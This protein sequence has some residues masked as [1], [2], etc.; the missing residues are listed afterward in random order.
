MEEKSNHS[1]NGVER[2]LDLRKIR[3]I[4]WK[5]WLIISRDKLRLIPLFIFPFIMVILFGTTA[6]VSPKHI[7]A[8]IVDYDNTPVSQS[9]QSL[10][11]SNEL[12]SIKTQVGSQE[13][14]KKLIDEGQISVLF[15]IPKGFTQELD[16]GNTADL[17]VII[18]QSDPSVAQITQASTEEFVQSVSQEITQQRIVMLT[19]EE[20]QLQSTLAQTKAAIAVPLMINNQPTVAKMDS[21]FRQGMYAGSLTSTALGGIAQQEV[22]SIGPPVSPDAV[23]QSNYVEGEV[24]LFALMQSDVQLG[25]YQQAESYQTLQHTSSMAVA[26]LQSVYGEARYIESTAEAEQGAAKISYNLIDA[27]SGQVAQLQNDTQNVAMNS[28]SLALNLIQPYGNGLRGIDYLL[29]N[30]LALIAFQGSVMGLG[31]AVAGERRDGSLT[32]VFLTPT[33]NITIIAGTLLYYVLQQSVQTMLIVLAAIAFFGLIVKGSLL[34]ILCIIVLFSA[35]SCGVGMIISVITRSQ[36]QYMAV[37]GLTSLPML[38]LAGVFIPIETMPAPLQ[39]LTRALPITYA[40]DALRGVMIKGFG[41]GQVIPD[42]TFLVAFGLVTMS[43]SLLIFKR[44]LI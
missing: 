17:D 29:P 19:K 42:L 41:L 30:I 36:E 43:L 35:G 2:L 24:P 18:D 5:N 13:E 22:S 16:S 33:S 15:I 1:G 40:A 27:T 11:Y 8:A 14:G 6:G 37:A 3:A 21:D 10:L 26:D 9:I 34:S 23:L 39:A 28:N 44:E 4:V 25:V 12:F 38:F 7:S 31:R 32:R 20:G